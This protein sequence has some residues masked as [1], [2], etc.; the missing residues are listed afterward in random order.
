MQTAKVPHVRVVGPPRTEDQVE[1]SRSEALKLG[2]DAPVRVSGQLADTP[3]VT[4]VGP[5]GMVTLDHGVVLAKRH[6]HMTPDDA[7]RPGVH[8]REI[9]EIAVD[10][11]GR[12]VDFG[13]VVVRVSSDYPLEFHLDT[14]EGNAAGLHDG[15]PVRLLTPV[16]VRARLRRTVLHPT[17]P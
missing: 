7:C 17:R 9:V 4:L 12:D 3:G 1:V 15:D 14:D 10:S 5:A 11:H 8:D 13:D 6:V 2:L 16:V